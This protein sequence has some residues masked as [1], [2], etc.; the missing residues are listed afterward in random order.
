MTAAQVYDKWVGKQVM[1]RGRKHQVFG[2]D[3][4]PQFKRPGHWLWLRTVG[5]EVFTLTAALEEVTEC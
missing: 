5:G 2:Y 4:Q 1:Y 3:P